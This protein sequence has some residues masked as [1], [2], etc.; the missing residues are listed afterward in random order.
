[1]YEDEL[2]DE[3]KRFIGLHAWEDESVALFRID[4]IKDE[5]RN[6]DYV[7]F[8]LVEILLLIDSYGRE[9]TLNDNGEFVISKLY[10]S[11]FI[12]GLEYD[13]DLIR[14]LKSIE[15]EYIKTNENIEIDA[16]EILFIMK[17]A[18]S[19]GLGNVK[20]HTQF[21]QFLNKQRGN[22]VVDG[23]EINQRENESF[24]KIIVAEDSS[25]D[26]ATNDE[27]EDKTSTQESLADYLASIKKII[28]TETTE[29]GFLKITY[30][31]GTV[32]VKDGPWI[33]KEVITL[34]DRMKK[35][36]EEREKQN[37]LK[38]DNKNEEVLQYINNLINPSSK[39]DIFNRIT[40]DET[41][42]INQTKEE[43]RNS[44]KNSQEEK[45]LIDLKIDASSNIFFQTVNGEKSFY[46][47]FGE[48]SSLDSFDS[49]LNSLGDDN[50]LTILCVI[51]SK[52]FTKKVISFDED[53]KIEFNFFLTDGDRYYIVYEYLVFMLL[54]LIENRD[55][56]FAE[57]LLYKKSSFTMR[58][59][60]PLVE[61][62]KNYFKSY[63]GL[64]IF[65]E[66][67]GENRFFK[68]FSFN[69]K[70]FKA[71]LVILGDEITEY[72]KKH[73]IEFLKFASPVQIYSD[74]EAKK[75]KKEKK[76]FYHIGFSEFKYVK[77]S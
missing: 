44:E 63:F 71:N 56:F 49:S 45:L 65:Y 10:L 77:N 59:P 27:V 35:E 40:T 39:E 13:M 73:S 46:G 17:N 5:F 26:E 15:K 64:D 12:Y 36:E 14:K 51:L 43:E 37:R 24:I 6:N 2:E 7:L 30:P 57:H 3:E 23:I 48:L 55:S 31:N 25:L 16:K 70:S 75:F 61:S 22:V 1:M 18:K 69:G 32:V 66:I 47:Y 34:E 53:N 52:D 21:F 41:K 33:I 58:F 4:E 29:D 11:N 76:F 28:K 67:K 62:F 9:I 60:V 68:H 72:L 54:S 74:E 50:L 42:E 8:Y 19:F 20:D 38:P